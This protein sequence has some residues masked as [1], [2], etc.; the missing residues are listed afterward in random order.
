MDICLN[1]NYWDSTEYG[2]VRYVFD[3]N[4][5]R[6]LASY[7]V[8]K[9]ELDNFVSQVLSKTRQNLSE[10]PPN[11]SEKKNMELDC[12]KAAGTF[13]TT[14][15]QWQEYERNK[16]NKPVIINQPAPQYT[17]PTYS[18]PSTTFCSGFGNMRYCS[19]F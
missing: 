16:A 6:T 15:S 2:I 17:L 10:K 12:K 14:Y 5:N 18:V 1:F 13:K 9:S 4:K 3:A 11:T 8:N 19:S 7:S